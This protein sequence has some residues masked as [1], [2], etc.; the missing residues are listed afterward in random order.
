M[1]MYCELA[2]MGRLFAEG[3]EKMIVLIEHGFTVTVM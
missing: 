2:E 3:R 1:G